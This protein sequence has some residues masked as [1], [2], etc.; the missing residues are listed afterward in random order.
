MRKYSEDLSKIVDGFEF[1]KNEKL[2]DLLVL[3]KENLQSG[4]EYIKTHGIKNIVIGNIGEHLLTNLDFLKYYE[5]IEV[6]FIGPD[7]IYLSGLAY[8]KNLKVFRS[9]ADLKDIID[10]NWFPVLE[11]CMI[12]WNKKYVKNIEKCTSLKSL[13]I[14]K[15]KS[16]S[17]E[18]LSGLHNLN[19]LDIKFSN[20][21]N[22]SGI[23]TLNKLKNLIFYTCSKLEDINDLKKLKAPLTELNFYKC[24]KIRDFSIVN[25][26][27]SLES[28]VLYGCGEIPSI[29]FIRDLPKL[30]DINFFETKVL[31]GDISP[32][33]GLEY[34]GFENKKHYSHTFEEI[35]ALNKS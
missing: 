15:Y 35:E 14:F 26:L 30:A 32:C 33:I 6:I 8:L 31:D 20:I 3:D 16:T 34:A 4:L 22:L 17:L 29:H 12:I 24:K 19:Y 21:N 2:G 27:M 10:F 28:L 13:S 1:W 5:F 7:N 9:S 11:E 25:K 23:E 18:T